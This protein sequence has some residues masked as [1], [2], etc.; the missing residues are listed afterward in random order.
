MTLREA[1]QQAL[2]ALETVADEVFS[3]YNDPIG[4]AILDLRVALAEP[5][6]TF[7]AEYKFRSYGYYK[8]ADGNLKLGDMP[9]EQNGS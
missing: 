9:E 5:E 7:M 6:Q 8:D 1:A 4:K 2:E 3:P